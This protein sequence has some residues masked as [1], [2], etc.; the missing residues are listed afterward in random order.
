[1]LRHFSR[2][3]AFIIET[4]AAR[5]SKDPK[6]GFDFSTRL[7]FS[8]E[9][10]LWHDFLLKLDR[11][12]KPQPSNCNNLKRRWSEELRSIENSALRKTVLIKRTMSLWVKKIACLKTCYSLEDLYYSKIPK[13]T[14][15]SISWYYR[16]DSASRQTGYWLF[17]RSKNAWKTIQL[18]IF[19]HQQILKN[20]NLMVILNP[21]QAI[22]NYRKFE[23]NFFKKDLKEILNYFANRVVQFSYNP[24]PQYSI[25]PIRVKIRLDYKIF[26]HRSPTR[27][28]RSMPLPA[29]CDTMILFRPII[30]AN[31]K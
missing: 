19:T 8:I 4:F 5:K 13:Q 3:R 7:N 10:N 22:A 24:V 14:E 18:Q 20:C 25:R 21:I 31:I 26:L 12:K 27:R 11:S 30:S 2:L 17:K 15:N 23:W 28:L 9:R 1:M 29:L 6:G 16:F